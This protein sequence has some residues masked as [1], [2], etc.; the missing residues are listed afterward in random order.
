MKHRADRQEQLKRLD[1][2]LLQLRDRHPL[3][4]GLLVLALGTAVF[5]LAMLLKFLLQGGR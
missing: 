5:G 4:F 3:L 2:W 1:A